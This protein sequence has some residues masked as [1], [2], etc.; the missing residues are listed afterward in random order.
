[1]ELSNENIA[2]TVEDIQKFFE[3]SK[4]SRRDVLKICLVVEEALL[5]WQERFGEEHKFKIYMRK[6][7]SAPKIV[8]RLA[9]EPFNPL[10]DNVADDDMIFSNETIKNLMHYDEAKTIYRYENGYNELISFS[11]KERKPLTIPGGSITISVVLAIAFSFIAGFLPQTV[12]NILLN[13]VVTPILDTLLQLIV[14]V[15]IF[16][17]FFAVI[18]SVC[19]IEDSTMLGNIGLTVIGRILFLNVCIILITIGIS[20]IFF[21]VNFIEN[22][23]DF[24]VSK[25]VELFLSI[26]PTNIPESFLK[27]NILQVT[28]L[29]FLI[30][31]CITLIGNQVTAVKNIVNELNE[32]VFKVTET[33]LKV[34]P[35]TIF[36]CIFKTLAENDFTEFFVVWKLVAASIIAYAIIIVLMLIP[37]KLKAKI[38]IPEFFKKIFPAF[39]IAFT[40]MN[41]SAALPKI[42]E[43][44]KEN[45]RVEEK[46]C[47]FWAPLAFV[48]FSPSELIAL[49]ICVIYGVSMVGNSLSMIDVCIITF[50]AIQLSI[51][52]PDAEGGIAAA[53][54]IILAQFDLPVEIIGALMISDV[55]IDNL[56]T[57]LDVVAHEC[58][59]LTVSHKMGFIKGDSA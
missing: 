57:G 10:K 5:R 9:D 41:G 43:V 45:L 59:L 4:V 36:L 50:I 53:Y 58:E 25:V 55:I 1:M 44:S 21:P 23:S 32:L 24:A 29:A 8:I 47:N 46:F 51:A 37:I 27:G 49:T 56:F 33:V 13:D 11:T 6:W 12:Q 31:V 18:S 7:F 22:D 52:T 34:I 26:I 40:T 30:G 3:E 16:M 42:I 54:G 15:T 28:V 39:I 14:T 2:K 19:A 35:L 20:D 17:V 48:L 38:G